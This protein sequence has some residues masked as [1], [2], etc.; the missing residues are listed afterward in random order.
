VNCPSALGSLC[1]I[2]YDTPHPFIKRFTLKNGKEKAP[3]FPATKQTVKKS[4]HFPFQFLFSFRF[5]LE[6]HTVMAWAMRKGL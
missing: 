5:F 3:S 4:M 1:Q 2:S 6:E